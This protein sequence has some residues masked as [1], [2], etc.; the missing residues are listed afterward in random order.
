MIF[1]LMGRRLDCRNINN[2][3]STCFTKHTST[4]TNVRINFAKLIKNSE[5]NTHSHNLDAYEQWLS[6][7]STNILTY[8]HFQHIV[9]T[10]SVPTPTPSYVLECVCQILKSK[11]G[12]PYKWQNGMEWKPKLLKKQ[13]LNKPEIRTESLRWINSSWD[14]VFGNSGECNH[15]RQVLYLQIV[16]NQERNVTTNKSNHK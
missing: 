12:L 5:E 7:H 1:A 10:H 8:Q 14:Y 11:K 3:V 2:S 4:H 16:Q 15:F 6:S 9:S 13:L